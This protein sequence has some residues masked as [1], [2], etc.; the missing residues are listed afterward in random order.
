MKRIELER[1]LLISPE[2]VKALAH[3]AESDEPVCLGLSTLEDAQLDAQFKLNRTLEIY[4][5]MSGPDSETQ[6]LLVGYAW[7]KDGDGAWLYGDGGWH[8]GPGETGYF[9]WKK[10]D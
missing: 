5:V 1:S 10:V 2:Q 8:Y 9:P 6:D 3:A 7:N 4:A